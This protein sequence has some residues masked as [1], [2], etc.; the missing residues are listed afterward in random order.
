M[1]VM[2]LLVVERDVHTLERKNYMQPWF[3]RCWNRYKFSEL[4]FSITVLL[5]YVSSPVNNF[6]WLIVRHL[7]SV[8]HVM[9]SITLGWD[10]EHT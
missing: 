9:R 10:S 1:S 6:L 4:S 7:K 3:W 5:C 8:H 2:S